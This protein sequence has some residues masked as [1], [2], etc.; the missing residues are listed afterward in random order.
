MRPELSI[1]RE[2]ERDALRID[3]IQEAAFGQPDEA[4]LVR[5]LRAEASPHL[6]L[7]ASSGGILVG[8]I[9]LSPVR[10][11]GAIPGPSCAGLAPVAVLP[12]AQGTGIGGALVRA[13]LSEC[14]ALGWKAV[15]LVGDPAYYSRFGFALAAPLGL[16]YESDAFDSAF[17]YVEIVPQSLEGIGGWVRFHEA[18]AAL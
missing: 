12:E 16:H 9:F 8:H 1:G 3:E 10:I 11:E 7:V 5:R 17:Q 18:F 15:F 6:S 14:P 13:A 2:R 4:R